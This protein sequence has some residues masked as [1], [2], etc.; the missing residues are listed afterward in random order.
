MLF[1]LCLV[2]A[3]WQKIGKHK[4]TKV[5][6][7]T[8]KK[9]KKWDRGIFRMETEIKPYRVLFPVVTHFP[10]GQYLIELTHTILSTFE[11]SL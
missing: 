3:S 9:K 2:S 4:I 1:S 11:F 6:P 10:C 5:Q 8:K 7:K